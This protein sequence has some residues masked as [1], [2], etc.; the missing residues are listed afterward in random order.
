MHPRHDRPCKHSDANT[1]ILR[2]I[3]QFSVTVL[4]ARCS[5]ER[6]VPLMVWRTPRLGDHFFVLARGQPEAWPAMEEL[7]RRQATASQST[8]GSLAALGM[9]NPFFTRAAGLRER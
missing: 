7:R 6:L 2:S 1:A 3:S 8:L 4:N 9:L 5:A